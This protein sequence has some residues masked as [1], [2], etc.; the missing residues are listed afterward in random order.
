MWLV[1]VSSKRY[2]IGLIEPVSIAPCYEILPADHFKKHD[3]DF[4]LLGIQVL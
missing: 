1:A 3:Q 2:F 4:V